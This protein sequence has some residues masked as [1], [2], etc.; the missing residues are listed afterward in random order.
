MFEHEVSIQMAMM[1]AAVT[2]ADRAQVRR[3]AHR[4][5]G[6]FIQ[7]GAQAL[8]ERC[9]EIEQ[10]G[11]DANLREIGDDLRCC[12][13]QTLDALRHRLQH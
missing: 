10:I 7:I 1:E 9:R 2:N 13:E 3:E 8:A 12:Y 5:R 6:G 4:M 11:E